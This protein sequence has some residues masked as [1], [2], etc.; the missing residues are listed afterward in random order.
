[1]IALDVGD[2]DGGASRFWGGAAGC[3]RGCAF[4]QTRYRAIGVDLWSIRIYILYSECCTRIAGTRPMSWPGLR[5]SFVQAHV[6]A[7][8][9]D[10]T[11]A[12]AFPSADS[13]QA[14]DST[15]A[16]QPQPTCQARPLNRKAAGGLLA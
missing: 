1:M 4:A 13:L 16:L 2:A 5:A 12:V 10:A 8:P 6:G 15:A 11:T 3:V 7:P 14:T 9:A